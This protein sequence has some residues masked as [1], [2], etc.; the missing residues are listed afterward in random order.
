MMSEHGQQPMRLL[1]AGGGTGGHVHPALAVLEELERREIATDPMWIGSRA[2]LEREAAARTG[3]HFLEIPTGKFRRYLDWR[4]P[5]DVARVPLGVARA[6]WYVRGYRP[7]VVFSTGGFVSVPTVI[8]AARLAPILTHEQT[9]T[10]GLATK[11][12]ARFADVLALSWE[13]SLRSAHGIRCRT[14]VTGNPIRAS[15]AAGNAERARFRYGFDAVLP[16]LYVTGGARGASPLNERIGAL[17]PDLL[18]HCQVLHQTGP[19]AANSD[20]AILRQARGTWP[21]EIRRRYQVVEFVGD[22]LADVYAAADLILGRAGAGT[23]AELACLGLP[24]VLI[25]LPDTGGDEQSR[26]A[27]LLSDAGGAVVIEQVEATP[28]RLRDALVDLLLDPGRRQSMAKKARAVGRPDAAA[29]LADEL[30]AL[31]GAG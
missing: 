22:E 6:W 8:A 26:N 24:S 28:E 13:A 25:P 19:P 4:T 10:L 16:F 14:V 2:G 23:V 11:I 20:A 27:R 12:N 18:S 7:E 21:E 17:L 31:R 15:L 3:I 1:I 30:L 5:L 9:A 29:R